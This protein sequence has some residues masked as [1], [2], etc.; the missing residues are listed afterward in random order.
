MHASCR[1][2][3]GGAAICSERRNEGSPHYLHLNFD[4]DNVRFASDGSSDVDGAGGV[5]LSWAFEQGMEM[6]GGASG[7][8]R[9]KSMRVHLF[10]T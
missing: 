8:E 2:K 4:A 10:L 5:R 3:D 7:M 9:V 6:R 1:D